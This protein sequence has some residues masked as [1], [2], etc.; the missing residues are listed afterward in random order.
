M[1]LAGSALPGGIH[2]R[3]VGEAVSRPYLDMTIALLR[4][5]GVELRRRGADLHV[6]HGPP[7]SRDFDVEGDWSSAVYPLLAGVLLGRDVLVPGMDNGSHQADRAFLRILRD[8]GATA[9]CSSDGARAGRKR[10][11]RAFRCD[12][13]DS[14]D[15]APAVAALA[16]FADG[17]TQVRGASHLRDKESDRI[18]ACV[19]AAVAL[20]ADARAT[21]DGFVIQGGSPSAGT[22]S[23]RGDHRMALAFHVASLALPGARVDDTRCVAKS[24]PRA[25]EAM[26]VLR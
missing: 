25:V 4:E 22:V 3:L 20:G 15:L 21:D 9:R 8:A 16:V 18:A 24:W 1:L 13:R 19:D 10:P 2:V 14:P 12:L 26:E 6:S 7:G 5:T 23:T 11:L 17:E